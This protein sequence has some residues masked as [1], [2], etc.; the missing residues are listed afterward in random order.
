MRAKLFASVAAIALVGFAA[1]PAQAFDWDFWKRNV[2]VHQNV[3]NNAWIWASF[4]PSGM[5]TVESVQTYIGDVVATAELYGDYLP[6]EEEEYGGGCY[7]GGG[8]GF[9]YGWPMPPMP[10]ADLTIDDLAHAVQDASA[11]GVASQIES[12][13]P[14]YAD[15]SQTLMGECFSPAEISASATAGVWFA[16]V[17]IAIDQSVSAVAVLSNIELTADKPFV[18]AANNADQPCGFFGCGGNYDSNIDQRD[19]LLL[20]YGFGYGDVA[21]YYPVD[22]NA[23]LQADINQFA[24]ADTSASA[25][26]FQ[27]LSQITD[28]GTYKGL[29]VKGL[30]ANQNVS[31]AGLVSS[32]SN[33][34][35]K[36][37][38]GTAD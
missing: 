30:V 36:T 32:V 12:N 33:L 4:Y 29:G 20:K 23:I 9:Q 2:N 8:C 21:T 1:A 10:S 38:K 22:T 19:T 27:D 24:H 11:L 17:E 7:S 3:F 26:A 14:I 34:I 25:I 37:V 15:L 16:P 28:L 13:V 31:A 6:D 18:I 35:D 5:T